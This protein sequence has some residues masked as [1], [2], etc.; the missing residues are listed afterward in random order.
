MQLGFVCH[1]RDRPSEGS[2][3]ER[4]FGT[5]NTDLFSNM[6][7]YTGSGTPRAS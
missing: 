2:I 6:P 5:F 3:V 7:G 1:L 4:P